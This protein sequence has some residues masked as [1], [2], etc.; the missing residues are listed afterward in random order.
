V[1]C[2]ALYAAVVSKSKVFQVLFS[3]EEKNRRTLI[4]DLSQKIKMTEYFYGNFLNAGNNIFMR[5]CLIN[6]L[7]SLVL[8]DSLNDEGVLVSFKNEEELHSKVSAWIEENKTK[9]KK[10]RT[11]V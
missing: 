6:E 11:G 4:K 9:L 1:C 8:G 3:R 5:D 2:R 10:L 7:E